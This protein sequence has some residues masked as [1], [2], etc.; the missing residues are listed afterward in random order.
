MDS[1]W[2]T[3]GKVARRFGYTTRWVEEQIA[4]RRLP[5]TA[6]VAGGKRSY[7]IRTSDVDAF[8]ASWFEVTG[9]AILNV[10]K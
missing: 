1:E 8:A 5:A 3:T 7:R 10:T 4:L 9:P 2:M 6:F